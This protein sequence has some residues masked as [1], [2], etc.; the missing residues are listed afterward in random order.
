MAWDP[1]FRPQLRALEAIRVPPEHGCGVALRDPSGLSKT[2]L[3]LSDGAVALVTLMDGAHTCARI[4]EELSALFGEPVPA[5]TIQQMLDHLERARFLDGPSFEAHYASL[6]A[7]YRSQPVR[8]TPPGSALEIL[9]DSEALFDEILAETKPV[10]IAGSVLGLIAPHLDYPRGHR[11]YGRAYA[12]LRGRAAPDRVVILGTNHYGRSASVVSTGRDFRTPLGITRVD[13]EFLDEL[14][15]RCGDLCEHELDHARE[16]SIELELAWLQHLFGSDR[17][18]LVPFLCPDP[19]GPTGTAP[20]DGDG[21]DLRDFARALGDLIAEDATDTLIVAGAD[22]SHVGAAFGD[23]RPLDAAFLAEVERQDRR[24][25]EYV[26][27][28]D[29]DGWA[30][31]IAESGNPTRICGTGCIFV[32]MAAVPDASG[33]LLEYDQAVDQATQTGVTCAAAALA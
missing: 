16:H 2:V 33:T 6:V 21:V 19:C 8:R 12:A 7:E 11:C 22:L 27:A 23:E 31:N 1:E 3:T 25:L 20:Y 28:A 13:R 5:D 30:R 32:L 4:R 18:L 14:E 15:A 10:D 9:H 29:A 24:A 17:F 26:V